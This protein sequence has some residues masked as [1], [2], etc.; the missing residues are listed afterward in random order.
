MGGVLL[1]SNPQDFCA[2]VRYGIYF[3]F[4]GEGVVE[5]GKRIK[6]CAFGGRR[7][8]QKMAETMGSTACGLS[9]YTARWGE[10]GDAS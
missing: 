10:E 1:K 2:R 9:H 8:R 7:L 5:A 6:F 4:Y 3:Y